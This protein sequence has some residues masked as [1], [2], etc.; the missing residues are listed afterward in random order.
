MGL[1]YGDPDELDRLA[2]VL[3]ARADEVRRRADEQLAEA[4]AAQ[5]AS[6]SA[7]A[8]R[9]R[10]AGRRAE[11]HDAADGL[12]QAAGVLAAHAQEVRERMAAIARIEEAVT[13]WFSRQAGEIVDGARSGVQQ[14]LSG[15]PPWSGWRFTPQSLPP[16]G[17]KG[18]LEVGEFMRGKG[19]L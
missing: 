18:W 5:W 10:L 8:Y 13:S 6:I 19:V 3:R 12:E 4:Q 17:D 14:V 11:A 7:D 16:P 15:E 2:G 9:D 1:P